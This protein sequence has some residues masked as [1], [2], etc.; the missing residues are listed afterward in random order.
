MSDE[1]YRRA[2]RD[3]QRQNQGIIAGVL[4]CVFAVLGILTFGILFVPIAALCAVIG[5]LRAAI[6]FNISGLAVSALGL[7]LS[8]VGVATSPSLLLVL[9]G[10]FVASQNEPA[11]VS[12]RINPVPSLITVSSDPWEQLRKEAEKNPEKLISCAVEGPETVHMPQGTCFEIMKLS[13]YQYKNLKPHGAYRLLQMCK[14]S[15][16]RVCFVV[17]KEVGHLVEKASSVSNPVLVNECAGDLQAELPNNEKTL[18]L[19]ACEELVALF[20]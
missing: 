20:N 14:N 13:R 12:D 15:T 10:I 9:G 1:V 16:T 18:F 4:A 7:I 19:N 5:L 11:R 17:V 2:F 8:I 6:A 3:A